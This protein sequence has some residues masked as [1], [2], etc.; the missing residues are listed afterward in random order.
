M[1]ELIP[2]TMAAIVLSILSHSAS[3]YDPIRCR[4]GRRDRF[5]F[6]IMAIAMVLFVGLRTQYNDTDNYEYIY[7]GVSKNIGLFEDL[8]WQ[9]GG[10]P[11]FNLTNRILVRLGFSTQSF[12]MFCSVIAVGINL[13]FLRKYSCNIPLTIFLY[14]ALDCYSFNMAAIKQ[15]L[16][17]ALAM[18]AVDRALQ[19]KYVS[20]VLWILV[21]AYFHPYALMYILVPFLIFRPWSLRSVLMMAIFAVAGMAMESMIGTLVDVTDLLGENFDADSFTGEGVNPFRVAV[22]SMPILVAWLTRSI[23]SK[24]DNK[25]QF[26]MANL[27]MLNAEI[28]F[29]GLFGSANYFA[30][31]ANYFLPF[32]ALAMP[33]LFTH[34]EPRSKKLI[35]YLAIAGY[36]MYFVFSNA[37]LSNFDYHYASIPLWDYLMSLF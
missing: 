20:F 18:V 11:L 32:Q 37:I 9:M 16:A 14:I 26:L 25:P 35:T 30:R 28:M 34:F 15:C 1:S 6:A 17:M 8:S 29:V 5:W 12:L 31:L 7:N 4:Y 19:K 36:G 27:A 10:N 2:I 13:W 24:E 3:E 33:W 22:V 21:A 23:I